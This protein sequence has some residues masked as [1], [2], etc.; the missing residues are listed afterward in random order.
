MRPSR[1]AFLAALLAPFSLAA[2][3]VASVVEEAGED[4]EP[5]TRREADRG[6]VLTIER[7]Y[8]SPSLTGPT[9]RNVKFS[10]DGSRITF[11]RPKEEDR[12]VLDLWAMDVDDGETY[13][14]VDA[15]VLA[16][17]ERELT[18]A[19]IQYRERARISS[20]GV[21]SYDWDQEGEAVLVPLDGDIFY[22]DIE[23]GEARRLMETEAFETDARVSP[24]GRYVSFIREQNLWVHDLETGEEH[25]LTTS[26]GGLISWGMAEFVAQEEMRR[27][28]G[29]WWSPDDARIAVARVDQSPVQVVERFGIS[30]EG[31]STSEQRYPRAG[32]DNAIVDLYMLELETRIGS[33]APDS[34]LVEVD[35]G[36]DENIYLARVD[37]AADGNTVYVQ[38]QNREQTRLD[39]LAADPVTGAAE[40]VLSESS[41]SWI[42]LTN[43][44]TPLT[45][46]GFLWTSER[47]GYRHIYHAGEDGE[48]R[49][50]TRGAFV[51]DEISGIS[52]DGETVYFEGWVEDPLQRHLYS[53][54]FDGSSEPASVTE[55]EGSW[56]ATLGPDAE[57]FVG[58]FSA[59]PHPAA[60]RALHCQWR[61]RCMAERKSAG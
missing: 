8:G 3:D 13:R 2:C 59:P 20:T 22:V 32:T 33:D 26:G 7:L 42:N 4:D 19:E 39:V 48:L 21:V 15:R 51:V 57:A 31:V 37:W 55:E 45:R 24:G 9:P 53:I 23:T 29:Y 56:A 38:R 14:L 36:D 6:Q 25:A 34:D 10:P 44:L 27:Y 35:L 47:T 49:Q 30:A 5:E 40:I 61:A 1:F 43:D 16:P 41:D 12:T 58:T 18:E 50:I 60:H 28:T 52:E 11:L 54:R 46:G 17:E